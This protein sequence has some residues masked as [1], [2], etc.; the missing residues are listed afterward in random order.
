[1][2]VILTNHVMYVPCLHFSSSF[3]NS[4]FHKVYR[5]GCKTSA[6]WACKHWICLFL[7]VEMNWMV[8]SKKHMKI[9]LSKLRSCKT[10]PTRYIQNNECTS[11]RS[12][13]SEESVGL[14]L[15]FWWSVWHGCGPLFYSRLALVRFL[16]SRA[17][18]CSYVQLII[19]M[20]LVVV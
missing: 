10:K 19:R 3:T 12:S 6:I 11:K 1:M 9:N 17:V 4:L 2:F 7:A 13:N 16:T 15:V 20:F 14:V 5:A 18:L 8:W